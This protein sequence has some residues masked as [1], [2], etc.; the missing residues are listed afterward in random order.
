STR[1]QEGLIMGILADFVVASPVDALNYESQVMSGQPLPA[2]R[3]ERFESGGL[4]YLAM[5]MLWAD[6]RHESWDV[7]HYD[8][9]MV[10]LEED[11]GSWLFRFPDELVKLL[12]LLDHAAA[13]QAADLWSR[14]EEVGGEP[15]VL[16]ELLLNLKRLSARA[17]ETE[18]SLYLWGSL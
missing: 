4:T 16:Q 18:R 9:E 7:G 13:R 6:L 10:Y 12:S 1:F 17:L 5:E 15:A 2:D 3:F 11:G 8:L 14:H